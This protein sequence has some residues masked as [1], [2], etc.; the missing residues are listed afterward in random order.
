[1]RRKNKRRN[2]NRI[3]KANGRRRI[4]REEFEFRVRQR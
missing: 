3:E 1:M 2:G 4:E